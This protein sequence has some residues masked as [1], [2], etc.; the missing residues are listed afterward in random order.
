MFTAA[1]ESEII[2]LTE[3]RQEEGTQWFNR[4]MGIIGRGRK[5]DDASFSRI[6]EAVE[7]VATSQA[8]IIDRF[9]TLETRHQ[10]DS[11][12]ITLLTTELAALK[13]NCARRTAIRRTGSPQ[14]VQPPT[15]WL[16]SDKTKEQ[17]FYESGDVRY[18]PQQAGLL[19]GA[20]G[21]A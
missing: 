13:E 12:K 9:N 1:M 14:Q 5:A 21:V 11:Q 19:Y 15:N 10:Q 7:G 16:T 18:Y 17:I 8:D 6:Q 20:A 3:Q 4:V 2:E